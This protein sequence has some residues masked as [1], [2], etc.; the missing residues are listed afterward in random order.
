MIASSEALL[1]I[2]LKDVAHVEDLD[3]FFFGISQYA[4]LQDGQI[5]G[6]T[7]LSLGSHS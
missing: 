4:L 1:F 6:S 2:I 5:R 7:S 3:H